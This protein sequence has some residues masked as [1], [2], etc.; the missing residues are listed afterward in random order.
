MR[1]ISILLIVSA[2]GTKA[3]LEVDSVSPA[4]GSVAGGTMVALQGA[5]FDRSTS[6]SI[7]GIACAPVTVQDSQH[8]TC[9]SGSSNFVEGAM[10]VVVADGGEQVT[11][12]A[13]FTYQCQWTTTYGRRTC[14]AAPPTEAAKQTTASWLTQF[15]PE[16]GFAT[17]DT[18]D[19]VLGAQSALLV[20]DGAG[21]TQTLVRYAGPAVDFTGKDLKIWVKVENVAHLRELFVLLGDS[22]LQS[23]YRFS[24]ASAQGQ[25]W[26]TEGDWV[27]FTVPWTPE[28]FTISGTPNRA[29]ITDF[30]IKVADDALAA[31]VRVHVNGLALVDEPTDYPRGV[32]SFTFD[33]NFAA[34]MDPGASTLTAHGFKATA[35]VIVDLVGKNGHASLDDLHSLASRGWDVAVHAD[36][37][38]VHSA[39]YSAVDGR[40]VEDDM[41]DAREW[42]IQNGFN[43][44]DHCA[45]PKG[46]FTGGS[47]DVLGLAQRY[48]TS[49]RTIFQR[50]RE[51]Y[52]PS[53]ARKL[54]VMYVTSA[55]PLASVEAA[56]DCAQQSHEWLILV[57][58]R[59]APVPS[60]TTE[61]PTADF[62]TLVDYVAASGIDVKPVTAVLAQ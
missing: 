27:S 43:G 62:A 38:A 3:P 34:M 33:D 22:H 7:G 49:C 4:I 31:P 56:I 18:S 59:F 39:A 44:Y 54:R 10:D 47:A 1:P 13:A 36:T 6:V 28:S 58:H 46:E 14:G 51:T 37:D 45:Y 40:T 60:V 9:V 15:Q 52:P 19:F 42:L 17:G 48:F 35:Y 55:V 53:D 12:A 41:V 8:I 21:T 61:W 29:A 30:A 57:F 23:Y 24:I 5:G 20:S 32:V 26:M 2:C 11:L 16:D 50:Q 25:Q